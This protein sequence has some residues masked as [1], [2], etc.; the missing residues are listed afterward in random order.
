[1][2][3]K[4]CNSQNIFEADEDVLSVLSNGNASIHDNDDRIFEMS[5][6][7]MLLHRLLESVN[8]T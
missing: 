1:M 3:D 8:P 4:E 7:S 5:G 6:S 2:S